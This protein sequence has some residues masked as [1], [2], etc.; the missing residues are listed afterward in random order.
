MRPWNGV[1]NYDEATGTVTVAGAFFEKRRRRLL[2]CCGSH[3][4]PQELAL[5]LGALRDRSSRYISDD[6]LRSLETFARRIRGEIFFA[7]RWLIVEGQVDY[8]IVH[9]LA[10][11]MEYDLDGFRVSVI[12]ARNNGS[13]V[14]FATLARAIDIPWFAVFDGDAA[15]NKYKKQLHKRGFDEVELKK[16]CPSHSAGDLEAQL[17]DDGFGS[18]LRG[19]LAELGVRGA[20]DLTDKALVKRLRK[21]VGYA[22]TLADR[23]RVDRK[24]ALSGPEAFRSG[25]GVLVA[26]NRKSVFDEEG[27]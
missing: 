8:L 23:F 7:E 2:A 6:E 25:I 5:A 15:G 24:M 14:A 4:R 1:L 20:S 12:D 26:L 9:A 19:V 18:E 21:K 10:H 27:S 3:E 22:A 11:A 16:L 17:V 13:P